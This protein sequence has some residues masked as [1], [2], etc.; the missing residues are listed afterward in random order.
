MCATHYHELSA[1]E[2]VLHGGRNFNISAKKQ[3]GELIFLR[4]ILPGAA[5]DS[6]GIEVAKL[7]G[8]PEG[9]IRQ[10]GRYLK[11]LESAAPDPNPGAHRGCRRSGHAV[12][13]Q[14]LSLRR[15]T[16]ISTGRHT[17]LDAMNTLYV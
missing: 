17:P 5:D 12:G 6:Y 3:N 7:A 15:A 1:L 16:G 4:K 10:A 14:L 9:I 11:A 13:R 8:M 2:G